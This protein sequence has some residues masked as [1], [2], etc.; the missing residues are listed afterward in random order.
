MRLLICD[1][2]YVFE[3][4]TVWLTEE[5]VPV[6]GMRH[7][8][9]TTCRYEKEQ[10]GPYNW[11]KIAILDTVQIDIKDGSM[12]WLPAIYRNQDDTM[13]W[14]SIHS[15]VESG[16][17]L[18][19]VQSES[20]PSGSEG[21]T[22]EGVDCSLM[23]KQGIKLT[24]I[25]DYFTF[26][27]S[28]FDDLLDKAANI[29][30]S[31]KNNLLKGD[32]LCDVIF[33]LLYAYILPIIP[34]L[35]LERMTISLI[36]NNIS[37]LLLVLPE[38]SEAAIT[39]NRQ[40]V[41]ESE[42]N[43]KEMLLSIIE[44][45]CKVEKN[46]FSNIFL[47]AESDDGN[48]RFSFDISLRSRSVQEI[49]MVTLKRNRMAQEKSKE[50]G[51]KLSNLLQS[52]YDK[53]P[54]S[55]SHL[56]DEKSS[57]FNIDD[58][59]WREDMD[60]IINIIKQEVFGKFEIM[61]ENCLTYKKM[62]LLCLDFC[63][64]ATYEQIYSLY[65]EKCLSTIKSLN[66]VCRLSTSSSE[67]IDNF[68]LKL[69][70]KNEIKRIMSRR[71]DLLATIRPNVEGIY[72]SLVAINVEK[73][74]LAKG[75]FLINV[76]GNIEKILEI[77][78]SESFGADDLLDTIVN[79]LR[80]FSSQLCISVKLLSDFH[81]FA[82]PDDCGKLSCVITSFEIAYNYLISSSNIDN[83][84]AGNNENDNVIAGNNEN[85]NVRAGNNENGSEQ[86]AHDA[87]DYNEASNEEQNVHKLS[88]DNQSNRTDTDNQLFEQIEVAW[89]EFMNQYN[90]WKD[91]R[92]NCIK[93]LREIAEKIRK[94]SFDTNVV[95]ITATSAGIISGAA[96]IAGFA[97][98]PVTAG[99]SSAL[100][101]G[102]VVGGGASALTSSGALIAKSVIQSNQGKRAQE[103]CTQ[104]KSVT[105][106]LLESL[107]RFN[108]LK[109]RYFQSLSD[110]DKKQRS[111]SRIARE[112][113]DIMHQVSTVS[114]ALS[115]LKTVSL[116]RVGSV[117]TGSA[118]AA[119]SFGNAF[120]V[121]RIAGIAISS[122]FIVLDTW[123]LVMSAIETHKG[124][125][126]QLYNSI[127]QIVNSL[128][129]EK[130]YYSTALKMCED[131]RIKGSHRFK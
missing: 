109:E 8:F 84:R 39:Q 73:S 36:I 67:W 47:F 27:G 113:M 86:L 46:S 13:V 104:N 79:V 49:V 118:E 15:Y 26:S 58:K 93:K 16:L 30:S 41:T 72:D 120:K 111:I 127:M 52:N 97:L 14:N 99:I 10:K 77:F 101:I 57:L 114:R 28:D 20:K 126:T 92:S 21:V 1:A 25:K 85:S 106:K 54:S 44:Y 122:V 42:E 80:M 55:I 119:T 59:S 103:V 95:N 29:V 71:E 115:P 128:E 62:S 4:P 48:N 102:S 24:G 87:K 11:I 74:L 38:Y 112:M 94:K 83:V 89:K 69:I 82:M 117:F 98:I 19:R 64:K 45:S 7:L 32:D 116:V 5:C 131:I 3:A 105:D 88:L 40:D 75:R 68:C 91:I 61:D 107:T 108:E 35:P 17:L 56:A 130:Q 22:K 18:E 100:I 125:K 43:R 63:L 31:F 37:S 51:M 2:E 129:V 70:E 60:I 76:V 66:K 124:N 65:Y 12:V 23:A 53:N 123:S 90:L 110:H 34:I 121:V 50:L 78:S 9:S 6:V 33:G 81:L 96:A